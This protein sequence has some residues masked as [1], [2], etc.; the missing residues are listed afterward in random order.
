LSSR[1]K[2]SVSSLNV[3]ITGASGGIGSAIARRIS[4]QYANIG[5]MGRT[6]ANLIQLKEEISTNCN[7]INTYVG[8][9]TDQSYVNSSVES[10]SKQV[11]GID[12]VVHC[13]GMGVRNHYDAIDSEEELGVLNVNL[14]ASF[15]LIK[16]VTPEL[17]ARGWGHFINLSTIGAFYW[18]PYQSAY[19]AGKAAFLAY[20]TSLNYELKEKNV[21]ISNVIFSGVDTKFLD[22]PN[23]GVY[24]KRGK[25]M[26]AEKFSEEIERILLSPRQYV[27]IGAKLNYFIARLSMFS[28]RFFQNIVERRNPAPE[29]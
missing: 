20:C 6:S 24:R 2:T 26:T 5:L 15:F 22:R 19:V 21:F 13:A 12:I 16:A 18:A 7:C 23:Y 17:I 10:F 1:N 25:L 11:G 8:D 27:V 28:P 29:R 14:Q 9:L 4:L 3:L